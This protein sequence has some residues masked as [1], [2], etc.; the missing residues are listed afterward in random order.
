MPAWAS[1]MKNMRGLI[2]FSRSYFYGIMGVQVPGGQVVIGEAVIDTGGF[3][4]LIDW[5]MAAQF[6][7]KVQV[8]N[9]GYL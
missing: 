4:S 7:L 1:H 9:S 5:D 6:G 8:G 3:R 2:E